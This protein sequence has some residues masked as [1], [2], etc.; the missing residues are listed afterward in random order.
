MGQINQQNNEP[1]SPS[2][3]QTAHRIVAQHFG[4]LQTQKVTSEAENYWRR[5]GTESGIQECLLDPKNLP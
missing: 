3:N 4:R 5:L 2:R 1:T